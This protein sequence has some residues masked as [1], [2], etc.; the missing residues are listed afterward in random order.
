MKQDRAAATARPAHVTGPRSRPAPGRRP[1]GARWDRLSAFAPVVNQA[2]AAT[3]AE[4]GAGT[5]DGARAPAIGTVAPPV[6]V[7]AAAS[8][9][10][11]PPGR[12]GTRMTSFQPARR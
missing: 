3:G 7:C 1:D 2:A 4:A 9:A 5:E 6:P 8:G 11:R 10:P 12:F